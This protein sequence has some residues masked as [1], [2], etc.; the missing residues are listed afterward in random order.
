M[1]Q[2]WNLV[3]Q[4]V[5]NNRCLAP[6]EFPVQGRPEFL[7]VEY[8]EDDGMDPDG[9]VADGAGVAGVVLVPLGELSDRAV[10]LVAGVDVGQV[11]VHVDE[12]EEEQGL[13]ALAAG[14]GLEEAQEVAER[15]AP[16][17]LLHEQLQMH[18]AHEDVRLLDQ[19]SEGVP[20]A[21]E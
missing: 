15:V 6:D 10:V 3:S 18:H 5:D 13:L 17:A 20:E 11:L 7:R 4:L 8:G 1:F 14:G 16:Q 9:A 19:R 12:V 21:V 2:L